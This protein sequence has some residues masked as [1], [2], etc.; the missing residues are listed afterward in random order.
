MGYFKSFFGH[1]RSLEKR[2]YER[3]NGEGSQQHVKSSFSCPRCMAA[4]LRCTA[5][6]FADPSM[7]YQ[8]L[9]HWFREVMLSMQRFRRH[10]LRWRRPY[11]ERKL[12]GLVSGFTGS[13]QAADGPISYITGVSENESH[14]DAS[15]V[16]HAATAAAISFHI[17]F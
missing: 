6:L 2:L 14:T 9:G 3:F 15:A 1:F 12:P 13:Q 16:A 7:Y 5:V 4:M 11:R 10:K 17:Q 8:L